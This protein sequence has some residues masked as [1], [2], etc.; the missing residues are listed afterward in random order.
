MGRS[1]VE[2]KVILLNVLAV[3][4]LRVGQPEKP[5]FKNRVLAI[6]QRQSEAQA[7]VVVGKTRQTVLAPTISARAR[8]IVTEVVPGVAVFAVIFANGAPLALAQVGSPLP[9]RDTTLPRLCKARDLGCR[10]FDRYG[11]GDF[12]GLLLETKCC[13]ARSLIQHKAGVKMKG[14]KTET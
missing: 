14:Q 9:P 4:A 7:L 13:C 12:I 8:L 11:V 6:P 2:I 10:L 3:V 1:R 5:L